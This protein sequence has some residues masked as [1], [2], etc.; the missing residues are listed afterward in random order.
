MLQVASSTSVVGVMVAVTSSSGLIK[1]MQMEEEEEEGTS[2]TPLL[3]TRCTH[4]HNHSGKDK[5]D[6]SFHLGPRDQREGCRVEETLLYVAVD[7]RPYSVLCRRKVPT[8][9]GSSTPVPSP[10]KNSVG[11]LSGRMMSQLHM[12]VAI[13][14]TPEGEEGEEEEE[15]ERQEIGHNLPF[16]RRELRPHAV[17]AGK[18]D[19]QN[20]PVPR[21]GATESN[22][23]W[24]D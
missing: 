1:L 4:H 7:S 17:Y 15:E 3:I 6:K 5:R 19:T 24:Q 9:G 13:V 18:W 22:E 8:K 21:Q 2:G 16:K 10:E 14:W 12:F 20:G 23:H 11:S